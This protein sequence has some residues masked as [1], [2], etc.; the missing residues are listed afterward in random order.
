MAAKG[1]QYYDVDSFP[2]WEVGSRFE[3]MRQGS[4]LFDWVDE[5]PRTTITVVGQAD[6]PDFRKY[7]VMHETYQKVRGRYRNEP[8]LGYIAQVEFHIYYHPRVRRMFVD[9]ARSYC[10]EMVDRLEKSDIDFLVI[11][12][13]IDL[14]KLGNELRQNIR[15]GWFRDLKVADVSTIGIFGPTVGESEEWD[16]FEQ[17]GRLRAIDLELTMG[18]RR[19]PTKIM[20]NRGVVLFE[21]FSESEALGLMLDIQEALDA[22]VVDE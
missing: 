20:S 15:G 18:D 5:G 3:T 7:H 12:R 19:L 13:N 8:I 16:R 14:I 9:T 2:E 10:K 1:Y 6:H 17:L 4:L 22:Y 21:S 11:P